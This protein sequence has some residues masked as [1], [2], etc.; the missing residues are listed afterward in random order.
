MWY[1]PVFILFEL[2]SPFLNFHWFSDKVGMTGSTAQLINGIFLTSSFFLCR[3]VWGTYNC[4]R[5][6][7]DFMKALQYQD[8]PEGQAWL[9]ASAA[10][11]TANAAAA[12]HRG[13]VLEAEIIKNSVPQ[14]FPIWIAGVY[15]GSY[16]ILMLLNVYWFGKMIETIR[17]RFEPPIGTKKDGK[18]EHVVMGRGLDDDGI[19]SIEVD[20]QEVRQRKQNRKI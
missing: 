9:K 13:D 6:F 5:V 1:A 8:S 19:K 20:A 4:F 7:P 18:K 14:Y 10:N 15:L 17:A 11:A 16:L 12:S 3:L 2:S